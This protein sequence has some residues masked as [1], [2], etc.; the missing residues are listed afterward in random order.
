MASLPS[1]RNLGYLVA[2]SERLNFTQAAAACFVTQSTLSAGIKELEDQL[3]VRLVERDRQR[4]LMTPIGLEVVERA[5]G[6]LAGAQDLVAVAAA[7]ADPLS[8]TL[9]LGAIPTIA[10]FV[11]PRV[12]PSAKQRHPRLRLVLREDLTP[13]LVERVR[14][15]ALDVALIALP[16]PTEG[17][18][19]RPLFDEEMWLIAPVGD[20]AAGPRALRATELDAARLLLLAEGHCLRDHTLRACGLEPARESSSRTEA[21]SL[22]TLVQMVDQ[23]WGI[24]LVPEMS[25]KSG[26]LAGTNLIAR[27]L[28]PPAPVRTIAL[29][30]RQSMPR[31]PAFEAIGDLIVEWRR[32]AVR[33]NVP[34]IGRRARSAARRPTA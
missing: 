7:A 15:G 18:R 22:L 26:A 30:A 16:Y 10:P 28:A 34:G 23:G 29:V 24:A 3:G 9:T 21:T 8:G 6:L 27:P 19:V 14:S 11:L 2:L 1:L 33:A 13:A 20:T 32:E 4:V 12:L 25:V 5:K 17:L 31:Q